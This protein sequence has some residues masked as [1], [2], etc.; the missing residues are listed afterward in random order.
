VQV[1]DHRGG[2]AVSQPTRWAVSPLDLDAHLLVSGKH[3]PGAL[4]TRCAALLP[5]MTTQYDQ[6]PGP[7]LCPV[8]WVTF[9]AIADPA[10]F[11]PGSGVSPRPAAG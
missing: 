9:R 4:K 10:E 3:P 11:T 5:E 6:P 8:C 2:E 1:A 7:R